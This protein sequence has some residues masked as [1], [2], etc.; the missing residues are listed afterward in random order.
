MPEPGDDEL[1]LGELREL[2]HAVQRRRRTVALDELVTAPELD[3]D[4]VARRLGRRRLRPTRRPRLAAEPRRESPR[5]R[6]EMFVLVPQAFDLRIAAGDVALEPFDL[7]GAGRLPRRRFGRP[8]VAVLGVARE[9]FDFGVAI[10]GDAREPLDLD[11]AV[12]RPRA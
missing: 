4:E 1:G 10:L 5:L 12:P 6:A 9:P 7:G 11:V 2:E 8:R 3:E